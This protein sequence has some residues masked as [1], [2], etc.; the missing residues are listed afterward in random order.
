[1]TKIV[2]VGTAFEFKRLFAKSFYCCF[3]I[4]LLNF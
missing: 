2:K 1:M 4:K 3:L